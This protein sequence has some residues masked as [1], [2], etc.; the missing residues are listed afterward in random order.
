MTTNLL[1]FEY[2]LVEVILQVFI[3]IVD[4]EL[5]ETVLVKVLKPKDIQDTNRATLQDKKQHN[6][7]G[8]AI[9]V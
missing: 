2:M 7:N 1:K 8:D 6:V 5:F 3:G 4:A 9:G